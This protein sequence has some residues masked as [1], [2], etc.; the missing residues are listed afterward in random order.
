MQR[1]QV[2]THRNYRNCRNE[3]PETG[4]CNSTTY[5]LYPSHAQKLRNTENITDTQHHNAFLDDLYVI[6]TPTRAATTFQTGA[7][8][9][10]T[11]VGVKSH[12]VKLQAWCRKT[13]LVMTKHRHRE[14]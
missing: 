6:S 13:T 9:V 7:E 3:N 4:C 12:L 2:Y 10:K 5:Q 14:G 11:D 8:E 1:I